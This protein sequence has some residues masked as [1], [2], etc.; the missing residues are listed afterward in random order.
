[1]PHPKS[2]FH[3]ME[4]EAMS[5]EA[6]AVRDKLCITAKCALDKGCGCL[7]VIDEALERQAAEIKR[8]KTILLAARKSIDPVVQ[9]KLIDAIDES[10][11]K[12]CTMQTT[13]RENVVC[14]RCKELEQTIKRQREALEQIKELETLE[15]GKLSTSGEIADRALCL[16]A[17][18]T[19]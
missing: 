6:K 15:D 11:F 3:H 17:S 18:I 16:F 8:L 13:A 14:E 10:L 12:G 9:F 7:E 19:N 2:H 4:C 1:M 5:A